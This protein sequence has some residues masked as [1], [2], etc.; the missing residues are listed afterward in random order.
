MQHR[1]ARTLIATAAA[2][3]TLATAHAEGPSRE[4]VRAEL[5][6]A[7]AAGLLDQPGEAGATE[8]VLAAREAYNARQTQVALAHQALDRELQ[9]AA[10]GASWPD[11][12]IYYEAGPQGPVMVLLIYDADGAL[13]SADSLTLAQVELDLD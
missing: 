3:F 9:A 7:R 4:Q 11:L 6:E 8:A 10:D 2:V 13:H 12:E 1:L 5:D